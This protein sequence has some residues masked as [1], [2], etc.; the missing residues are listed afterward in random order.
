[1]AGNLTLLKRLRPLN[2]KLQSFFS[3]DDPFIQKHRGPNTEFHLL[4][5][6]GRYKGIVDGFFPYTPSEDAKRTKV[7]VFWLDTKNKHYKYWKK[8]VTIK[9][10]DFVFDFRKNFKVKGRVSDSGKTNDFDYYFVTIAELVHPALNYT[11]KRK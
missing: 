8:F 6:R 11:L 10:E 9:G 7:Y 2:E 3:D 4:P 1:M 5:P